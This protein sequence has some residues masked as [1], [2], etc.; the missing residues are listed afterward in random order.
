MNASWRQSLGQD[1]FTIWM[2]A[3]GALCAGL[4][5]NQL[6]DRPL[7]LI[8]ISKQQ[9]LNDAVARLAKDQ[10]IA[11]ADKPQAIGLQEFAGFVKRND[12]L[13]FD[14]RPAVYF[15][16]GHVPGALNLER[17]EFERDFDR[18]REKLE[19]NRNQV[20]VVYCSRATCD[21][22]QM[23]AEALVK[24]GFRR[25][26]LFKDGWDEWTRDQMPEEK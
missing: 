16:Q 25:T 5:V 20:L 2:L 12:A 11:A 23:V 10:V 22:G 8:Y 6:R 19:K 24:L 21:D 18:H 14:A 9:R 15:R 4:L 17:E 3:T 7:P 13:L 1:L 26:L